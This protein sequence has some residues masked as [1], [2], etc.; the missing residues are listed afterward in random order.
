[1]VIFPL[2]GLSELFEIQ[3]Y[4][5][6]MLFWVKT[7]LIPRPCSLPSFMNV[8]KLSKP[9]G[10]LSWGDAESLTNLTGEQLTV[11]VPVSADSPSS[12]TVPGSSPNSNLFQLVHKA[13]VWR[14]DAIVLR[15]IVKDNKLMA[16]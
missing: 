6:A 4:P 8:M 14:W 9:G 13:G 3:T 10:K 11:N 16:S 5:G 1:M 15:S 7:S 2:R 12:I